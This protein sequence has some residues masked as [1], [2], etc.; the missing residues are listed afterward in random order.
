MKTLLICKLNKNRF[1]KE[2]L[3]Y[4]KRRKKHKINA[5]ITVLISYSKIIIW[6]MSA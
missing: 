4:F 5:F 1:H 2:Y 3:P 6:R